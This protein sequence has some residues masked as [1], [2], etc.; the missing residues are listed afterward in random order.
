MS[1]ITIPKKGDYIRTYSGVKFWPL[2]PDV[3]DINPED[4]A[5]ALAQKVRWQ[6]HCSHFYSVGQHSLRV[7]RAS[8]IVGNLEY[9]ETTEEDDN[10]LYMYGLLHDANEAYLPDV[11][12]P[13]K[14]LIKGWKRIEHNVDKVILDA[15]GLPQMSK[16]QKRIV[17]IADKALL[18]MEADELFPK[19]AKRHQH[20]PLPQRLR[21]PQELVSA[22]HVSLFPAESTEGQLLREMHTILKI[23]LGQ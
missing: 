9:G 5:H 22:V 10:L 11:P 12:S 4:I 16:E 21:L 14:P 1:V 3:Q 7:A 19:S 6:G 8:K 2:Q 18:Q 15:F 23:N 13:L 17:K 20:W